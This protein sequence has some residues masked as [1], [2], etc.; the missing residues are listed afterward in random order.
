MT[1]KDPVLRFLASDVLGH[2]GGAA[3]PALRA[4]LASDDPDAQRAAAEALGSIGPAAG[5][6]LPDLVR[7][8][9]EPE[10]INPARRKRAAKP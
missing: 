3:V 4:V 5:V 8:V 1:S 2:C 9:G 6:A 7:L 10:A